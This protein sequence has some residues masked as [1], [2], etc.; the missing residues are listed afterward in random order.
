MTA[1]LHVQQRQREFI[2]S[3]VGHIS[4]VS[5]LENIEEAR[6][7]MIDAVADAASLRLSE[8][9]HNDEFR[10]ATLGLSAR[11]GSFESEAPAN[12]TSTELGGDEWDVVEPNPLPVAAP[13]DMCYQVLHRVTCDTQPTK[14][15]FDSPRYH[16]M[17][18]RDSGGEWLVLDADSP[19]RDRAPL[20]LSGH[21]FLPNL[22][23][24]LDQ[25]DQ[26][27]FLVFEEYKCSHDTNATRLA[28]S[29]GT[30]VHLVSG[31][32]CTLLD[33]WLQGKQHPTF[34]PGLELHPPYP[35]FYHNRDLLGDSRRGRPLSQSGAWA[36]ALCGFI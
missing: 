28:Q 17:N 1:D 24:Y 7:G 15:F 33:S 3:E 23:S 20:H 25:N 12:R 26:L 29:S 34:R 31:S 11:Q 19:L 36:E 6:M 14:I 21:R 5:E 27:S 30:C 9:I 4:D 32:L 18:G 35:W 8:I 13:S 2:R 16:H 22:K 10:V